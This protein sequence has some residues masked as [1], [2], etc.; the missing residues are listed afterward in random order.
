[1]VVC[2]P[3]A[4]R[5]PVASS[6]RKETVELLWVRF[7]VESLPWQQRALRA[8]HPDESAPLHRPVAVAT[9]PPTTTSWMSWMLQQ[10]KAVDEHLCV[11]LQ[12]SAAVGA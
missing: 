8:S 4:T 12:Q 11:A 2:L 3:A 7:P 9:R 1:M 5:P 6:R 10:T